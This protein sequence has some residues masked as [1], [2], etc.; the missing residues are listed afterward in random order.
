MG[1]NDATVREVLFHGVSFSYE[2]GTQLLL[3]GV[4]LHL[5]VGWTG[6]VGAN[7]AGKTTLLEL[8]TGRLR[9]LAGTVQT[10]RAVYCPQRTDDPPEGMAGLLGDLEGGTLELRG[11]LGIDDDWLERWSTL[12]HGERKRAQIGV[13]LWREPDV[14]A[15]DEP[16]NHLDTAARGMLFAALRQ[17]RGVGLLVSH[18]RELLDRLCR[19]CAFV[20]PPEVCLRPGGYSQGTEQDALEQE[21]AQREREQAKREVKRL[22][23]E[24]VQRRAEAERSNARR[25]KR[26]LGKDNDARFKRN[27]ARMSGKDGQAG[28]LLRQMDGRVEQ[29]RERQEGIRVKKRRDLGIWVAG[30][31][32][33]RDVLLRREAG[34]LPLG[35]GRHLHHPD[36]A[37]QPGDRVALTGPNGGGKST[38]LRQLMESLTLPEER[39]TYVPQEIDA[40]ASRQVMERAQALPP[41]ERGKLMT[42]V[43]CLGS[44]PGRLLESEL[45]SPGEVRKLLLAFGVARVPHFIVMDE[46]TNH[47]DLPSIECLEQ[48]LAGCPCG[49]LLVSHDERF[50]QQLTHRRWRLEPAASG[51]SARALEGAAREMAATGTEGTP[52][53]GDTVLRVVEGWEREAVDPP[54]LEQ[55]RE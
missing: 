37:M 42:V 49:L 31:R 32:S 44:D 39:V 20:E 25:S 46:P 5:P 41:A 6:V 53:R 23:R 36:L 15:V 16:T 26:N 12:S 54:T 43:S 29:A 10:G 21:T 30:E 55:L 2:S 52:V 33:K 13:A 8:A 35:A 22:E 45:P 48:A 27:L 34:Q 47:L 7:G 14:L 18:D 11:R 38:L 1:S 4:E 17:Y 50:L 19:Q 40:A 9:P 28:R 3:A 24:A 51:G